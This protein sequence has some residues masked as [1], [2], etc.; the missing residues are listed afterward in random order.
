M[1]RV[2]LS[3]TTLCAVA[4]TGTA[5]QSPLADQLAREIAQTGAAVERVVPADQRTP[6]QTRLTRA[7][8]A[9]DAGRLH[10]ALYELEGAFVMANAFAFVNEQTAVKTD[11][12]FATKWRTAGEPKPKAAPAADAPALVRAMAASG[13]RRAPITYRAAMPYG[14]DAGVEAGLYYL[15]EA[16]ALTALADWVSALGWKRE[17]SA[18][19]IRSIQP[20]LEAFDAEVTKAYENMTQTEHPTYIVV[21]VLIKRARTLND[22]GDYPGALFEYLLARLRFGSLRKAAETPADEKTLADARAQLTAGVDHSV[23]RVFVE[24]AEAAL[25]GTDATQRRNA[26][27]IVK[28]VL[29]AYHAALSR[30]K[31]TTTVATDPAVTVTLVRWPFT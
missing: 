5:A 17:G 30:A 14:Q 2:L 26:G 23:A 4:W 7:K 20:E 29:P 3:I 12:E 9:L 6:A 21:S 15:G 11:E 8:A 13:T 19:S 18:P 28:D 25:A 16:R 22:N 27:F 31:T 10:L 1:R 24:M